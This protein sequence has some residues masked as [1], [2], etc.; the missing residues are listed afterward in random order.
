MADVLFGLSYY[1]VWFAALYLVVIQKPML[2]LGC[3][4]VVSL[5][6]GRLYRER[7]I[8]LPY[9]R[10]I[11]LWIVLGF[12]LDWAAQFFTLIR[13]QGG[14]K[15]FIVPWMLGMWGNF[16]LVCLIT[17]ARLYQM[18]VFLRPL[19][20][21]GFPLAYAAGI[22]MG[23][24]STENF[25]GLMVCLACFGGLIFPVLFRRSCPK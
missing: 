6:Q 10:I 2:A 15:F 17:R 7:F 4:I 1:L 13:F 16:G 3:I 11:M 21:V 5:L 8:H 9:M 24:A 23:V 18:G 19:A 22:R 20:A 14:L 12:L 25:G